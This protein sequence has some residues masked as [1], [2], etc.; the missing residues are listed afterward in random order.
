MTPAD[1]AATA[2]ERIIRTLQADE[3][4]PAISAAVTR[5]DRPA[6]TFHIGDAGAGRPVRPAT[7]F[8][9]G[10]VTKTFTAVLVLQ[11]RDAGMLD[12]DDQLDAHLALPAHGQLTIRSVLNH[13][14]G[15]QREPWGNL[16][17]TIDVPDG[18]RLLEEV[19]KAEAVLSPRRRWHYSN[20]GFALLG[21][22]VAAKT[23]SSWPDVLQDRL[24][25]PLG[26]TDTTVQPRD[27]AAQ[28]Y[29]VEAYSDFARPEPH[30]DLAGAAAAAQLWSTADDMARWALFLA[31][32]DP[33]VIARSTLEE[34]YEPVVVTDP[35]HWHTGWG[36]GLQVAPQGIGSD[37]A[38]DIGHNGAMPGFLAGVWCRRGVTIGAAV[39][40]SSGTAGGIVA[41][42]HQLIAASLREDPMDVEPFVIGDA[43]PREY[44]GILGRWWSEG[45]EFV[46]RWTKGHL[47]ARSASAVAAAPPAVFAFEAPDLLRT[48]SGREAGERLELFRDPDGTVSY[49]RWAT[50][51]FT[52]DQETYA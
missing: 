15:L 49:M 5:A 51:R 4:V 39:L 32:P 31:Q 6:W 3:R 40:G 24:L 22:L 38:I 10:S 30:F 25:T 28:G 42:P 52:R 19:A 17:D 50:Y 35:V 48:V 16:W 21:H 29:L 36:L 26:L 45:S 2:C 11:L 13:T 9:I 46:F 23:G 1:E 37:R 47:E 43:A 34:M 14:S 33:A 41:A 27:D 18:P 44:A 7:Q 8:R 20:L 12:L